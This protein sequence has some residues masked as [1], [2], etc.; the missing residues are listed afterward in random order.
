MRRKSCYSHTS[1]NI[2]QYNEL[3]AQQGARR[4]PF[5]IHQRN[6]TSCSY[7]LY[8]VYISLKHPPPHRNRLANKTLLYREKK[9]RACMRAKIYARRFFIE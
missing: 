7:L 6:Q 2:S 4:F 3:R 5:P 9:L 8:Y 1:E